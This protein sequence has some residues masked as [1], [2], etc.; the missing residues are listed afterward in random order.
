[1][2]ASAREGATASS[3][4]PSSAKACIDTQHFEIEHRESS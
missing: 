2:K 1:M 4:V 3:N